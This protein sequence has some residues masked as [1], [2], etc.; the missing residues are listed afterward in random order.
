MHVD[1]LKISPS[2]RYSLLTSLIVPRPIAWVTSVGKSGVV[3]LAPFSYFNVMGSKPPI[4]VFAPGNKP[5]GALKDTAKNIKESGEF[6]VNLLEEE[7][8][9]QMVESAKPHSAEVSELEYTGLTALASLE[10]KVPRVKEAPVSM[11]CRHHQTIEI[12]QNRMMVGEV[13]HVHVKDGLID[14]ESFDLTGSYSPIGRMASP[15][16]YCRTTDTFRCS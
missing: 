15:D 12:G 6:V 2:D 3:N 11:E 9:P 1:L 10:V 16:M 5:S 13:L 14:P 8:M 7:L 4:I